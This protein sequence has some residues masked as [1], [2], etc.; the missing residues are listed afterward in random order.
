MTQKYLKLICR[1]S[2]IE[3]FN[4]DGLLLL[5]FN[6]E[7]PEP[8]AREKRPVLLWAGPGNWGLPPT[9]RDR[10]RLRWATVALW[11]TCLNKVLHLKVSSPWIQHSS[12]F[13]FSSTTPAHFNVIISNPLSMFN[14]V[15]PVATF[16]FSSKIRR[17]KRLLN[18]RN[19][20]YHDYWG[21]TNYRNGP[22]RTET[23][24]N[25][26]TKYRNGLLWVPKRTTTDFR[27]TETDRNRLQ[28]IPKRILIKVCMYWWVGM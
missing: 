3:V 13:A 8:F 24:R 20:Y 18:A 10:T 11:A 5:Y 1:S 16:W 28:L 12:T 22:E 4:R 17:S 26:P 14:D 25:G 15:H 9:V 19:S 7:L 27:G 21:V 6:I 23:D 2:S